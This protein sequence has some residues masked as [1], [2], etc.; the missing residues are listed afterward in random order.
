VAPRLILLANHG[1]IA[2][3]PTPAS[4]I[5]TTL[6]AAKAAEIFLGAAMLNGP[7]FLPRNQ[8]ARIAGRPDEHYRR[9][10]LGL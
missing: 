6:M 5:A 3:G 10:A 4:V 8:V 2:V 7:R 9:K 1:M